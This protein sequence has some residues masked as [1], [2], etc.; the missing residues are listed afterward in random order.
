MKKLDSAIRVYFKLMKDLKIF[1][2]YCD[3][4]NM[5]EIDAKK[6][7]MYDKLFHPENYTAE[8]LEKE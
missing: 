8:E 7:I 1:H 6:W 3:P 4:Y 5:T 2:G